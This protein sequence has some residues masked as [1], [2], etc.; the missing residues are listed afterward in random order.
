MSANASPWTIIQRTSVVLGLLMLASGLMANTLVSSETVTFDSQAEYAPAD[1][2]G[3]FS[4]MID[5]EEPSVI[6][7]HRSRS[8]GEF[9][10]SAS[11]NVAWRSQLQSLQAQRVDRMSQI[12]GRSASPSHYYLDLRNGVSVRLTPSEAD[13]VASIDGIKSIERVRRYSLDTFRGPD[14][15]GAPAIWDGSATPDGSPLRGELMVAAIL[16]SGIG[17]PT[18]HPSFDNDPACGHGV[19]AVPDKVLSN[20]DCSSTDVDGLCN[21]TL[22]PFDENGHGSH[23]ASTTA[24]NIVTNADTPSPELPPEFDS[25][26]GVAYCAH[27]R[28]YDVCSAAGG[29]SCDGDELQAAFASVLIHTDPAVIGGIPPVSVMN[30]SISGGRSPWGDFDRT[31]LDLV[32]A[33]VFVAASAG[34]TSA[35]EPDPVGLVSHRGPWVM[36]VAASTH[37]G[38]IFDGNVSLAGGPQDVAALEGSGPVLGATYTGQ[39]RWAGDVDVANN[40]GCDPFPADSFDGE[41]ALIERG[42]CPFVDKVTNATDAGAE[43]VIVFTD[44]RTPVNMAGLEDSTVSAFMIQ[45]QPG[46]DMATALGG[47]TA[48]VTVVPETVGVI[49]PATGDILAGFSLR[50]PTPAPLQDLQKP[51]ITAPGVNIFAADVVA[52][53][54]FG[55]GFKSGTSMSSPHV[56]GSAVLV[57]QA[58]PDWTVSEV[59]SAMQMTASRDGFKEDGT[60]AW[61]WD[62]VGHGRVDLNDAALAGFVMDETF[63]NYLAADPSDGGDVKTLNTPDIRN[64]VCSPDC[65]FTRTIRNTYDV[66]TDWTVTV[67]SF[68][69]DVDIQVTPTQFSFTGDTNE[70]QEITIDVEVLGNMLGEIEFGVILFDEDSDAAPQAHFTTAISGDLETPAAAAVDETDFTLL[71]EEGES[72]SASFNITNVGEGPAVADLTYSIEEAAPAT[73]V[74]GA[75]EASPPQDIELVLDGVAGGIA[76]VGVPN[77]NYLWFNQF[78]PTPLDLP[79]ELTEIEYLEFVNGADV[80]VGDEYDVFVWSDPDRA[81]GSGDEVLLSQ[82]LGETLDATGFATITLPSPVSITAETGDVLIGLVNRSLRDPSFAANGETT[83]PSQGRSWIAFNFPDG[84]AGS[85]PDLTAAG[86][87]ATIDALGLPRNW[88]IRGFGTGGSACL[89]PS[90]VPWLTV[91][92]ASGAVAQGESEEVV[93]DVDTTGLAQGSYEAR[94]CVNTSDPNNP[95]FVI[96]VTV[97]VTGVGGLPT[98]ELSDSSLTTAVDVL[99]TTGSTTFDISNLG[100][101]LDLEWTITEAAAG[102]AANPSFNLNSTSKDDSHG[103]AFGTLNGSAL[104][105]SDALRG[106]DRYS[107]DAIRSQF[108]F[109]ELISVDGQESSAAYGSSEPPPNVNSSQTVNIGEN[110]RVIGFG[111]EVNIATFGG[112]WLSE[113]S[114]AVV[115]A[116]GDQAGLFVSPGVLDEFPGEEAY[117]SGGLIL[118]SDAQIPAIAADGSGDVY[119][120]YYET[121]DDDLFGPL[122]VDAEWSDSASPE[123]LAAGLSLL[124]GPV[125]DSPSDVSWLSVDPSSGTTAAASSST[126]TVNVDATDLAPGTYEAL[127]CVNSNDP[128]QPLIQVPVSMEVAVPANAALIEGTV[129]SLG[130]CEANP[131]AAAGAS[132]EIVG[133][134]DT[135]NLTADADGFYSTYLDAGNGPVDVTASAPE[136]VSDTQA[137]V[138]IVGET[139]TTVDFGLVQLV[140]CAEID[141]EPVSSVSL[142]AGETSAVDLTI[143]NSNGAAAFDWSVE[144]EAV[145][146]VDPRGH[147]PAEPWQGA[148]SSSDFSTTVDPYWEDYAGDNSVADGVLFGA[149]GGPTAFTTTG[150]GAEGYISLDV[151]DPGNPTIINATQPLDTWAATFVDGDFSQQYAL[152][153]TSTGDIPFNTFG[154]IDVATGVFTALGNVTGAPSTGVWLSMKWDGTTQTLYAL[155]ET[156]AGAGLVSQLYTI[157]VD[158][159]E[160]TL[161]GELDGSSGHVAIAINNAGQMFGLDLANDVLTAIDKADGTAVPIGPLGIDGNFVQDMDFDRTTDTLY[162]SA[163][164]GGG[165]SRMTTVDLTT[166]AATEVGTIGGENELLSTSIATPFPPEGCV[167]PSIVP[168]VLVV[169]TSGS[170]D[171]G[172]AEEVS[173]IFDSRDLDSG[174]YQANLCFTTTDAGNPLITVPVNLIVNDGLFQDRF[175]Q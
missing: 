154:S 129:E 125:C 159:F 158:T 111:Y 2:Q 66:A 107:A 145:I 93:I 94:V 104:V 109:V 4:Y 102:G 71:L 100:N 77:Q 98:I 16:D 43:F 175:E 1:E 162:W 78:T 81:P 54:A 63:A 53:G 47:G 85:P 90:D 119:L 140:A 41:A 21:G 148:G 57:R 131:F 127:L 30:Y 15:I 169:P 76:R 95:T 151:L 18:I 48:E 9:E 134:I 118:L 24:G 3:R 116:E 26:S 112:S 11:A 45:R 160:A 167:D 46:L 168:W 173:V 39:L 144:T 161:V 75:R 122:G 96:P 89:T 171:A 5:F 23:T 123:V 36:S 67:D 87:F 40:L 25:I 149:G 55:F 73:V 97:E 163:Y 120:E 124:V 20:L 6:D 42:V 147:F 132:V 105:S 52:G 117:S 60:T 34:N 32:D 106:L 79:F 37:D 69:S 170:V 103:F 64:V 130:R 51:N 22:N 62:D 88:V 115:T 13:R 31:K 92:P 138:T 35:G 61:D 29:N 58:N 108:P 19:G 7:Q 166:G 65:S 157:D 99:N 49:D 14:F 72:G 172:D 143:D 114:V 59:K 83:T 141:G 44:D 146:S 84:L 136:H 152:G 70:T 10:R 28:S 128:S 155:L 137:G 153:S 135:F 139:T 82:V 8:S 174:L 50:G 27:I 156:D 165:D 38:Q 110:N 12:L 150:F 126:I 91:T 133:S 113:A 101:D 68:G 86:S 80:Q 164:L 142:E 17:D 121:F 33:G 56:A 74:L